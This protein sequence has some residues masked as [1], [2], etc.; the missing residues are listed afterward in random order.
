MTELFTISAN[1][2]RPS[3]L[4]KVFAAALARVARRHSTCP[5]ST[6]IITGTVR[7]VA[8]AAALVTGLF[9]SQAA[10]THNAIAL[11]SLYSL[12]LQTVCGPGPF[13]TP[14]PFLFCVF[15]ND[16]YPAG[17]EHMEA[18]RRGNGELIRSRTMRPRQPMYGLRLPA[19]VLHV[20]LLTHLCAAFFTCRR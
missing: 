4:R 3:L 15:H 13:P 12:P 10:L 1:C 5:M 7:R 9:T 19:S 14:D 8:A 17:N 16:A 11:S 2:C 18:P 6:S 20:L